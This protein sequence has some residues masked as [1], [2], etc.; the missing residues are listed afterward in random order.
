MPV[1]KERRLHTELIY[2]KRATWKGCISAQKFA[3]VENDYKF[4][5]RVKSFRIV[6]IAEPLFWRC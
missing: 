4:G 5:G 2:W 1:L 3:K 6:F